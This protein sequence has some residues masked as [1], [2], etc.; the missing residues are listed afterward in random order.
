MAQ[1][2]ATS[3]D[4]ATAALE[5]IA[6]GGVAAVAVEELAPRV[7]APEGSFYGHFQDRAELLE[8]ALDLWEKTRTDAIIEELED[9][10]DPLERLRRACAICF[11]SPYA[12]RIEPALT[13]EQA[14]D[15]IQAVLQRVT[16]RRI[17][18]LAQTFMEV[19]FEPLEA[20]QRAAIMYSTYLGFF[21]AQGHAEAIPQRG[22]ALDAYVDELV[23]MLTSVRTTAGN[24]EPSVQAA[25]D[26]LTTRQREVLR[27]LALGHTNQEIAEALVLSVRTVETHRSHVMQKLRIT[28]RA[29]LVRYAL[30]R[31]LL[32]D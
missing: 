4:W 7:G 6:E 14:G 31:G 23:Q 2:R 26:P 1:T 21:A 27:L 20:R 22:S 30:E 19:G 17:D 15:G 11:T 10:E 9:V 24:E 32:T 18:F 28:S 13:S 8:A 5:A 25:E 16:E 29:E 12:G 3:G